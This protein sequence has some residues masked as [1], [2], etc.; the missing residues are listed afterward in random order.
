MSLAAP[1][2]VGLLLIGRIALDGAGTSHALDTYGPAI[3][4]RSTFANHFKR[5]SN[6]VLILR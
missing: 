4:Q 3:I 2:M 1:Q 6:V 5:Y